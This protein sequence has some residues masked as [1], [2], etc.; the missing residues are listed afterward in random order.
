MKRDKRLETRE[1]KEEERGGK[2][3]GPGF[4]VLDSPY[5]CERDP[6][7]GHV[8]YVRY[9][10]ESEN[11]PYY[12][13][14]VPTGNREEGLLYLPTYLPTYQCFFNFSFLEFWQPG[15]EKK[16]GCETYKGALRE[17]KRAQV[18]T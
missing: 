11:G 18:A 17:N 3:P 2:G 8:P 9:L 1:T 7:S 6:H 12:L 16:G 14:K 4:L 13:C 5:C 10:L 15:D